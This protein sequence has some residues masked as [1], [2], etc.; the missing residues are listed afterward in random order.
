MI[1]HNTYRPQY[2]EALTIVLNYA[3]TIEEKTMKK[4]MSLQKTI[5]TECRTKQ[6]MLQDLIN[7]QEK[8]LMAK[9]KYECLQAKLD[10]HSNN[11]LVQQCRGI[12]PLDSVI[13]MAQHVERCLAFYDY[14]NIKVQTKC[15]TI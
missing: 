7:A 1:N 11:K 8:C 6:K 14:Y 10:K 2:I 15:N 13:L 12:T 5:C 9:A 3:I 4:N